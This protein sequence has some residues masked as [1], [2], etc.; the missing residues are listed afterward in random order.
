MVWIGMCA[1]HQSKWNNYEWKTACWSDK[2]TMTATAT[3]G[4]NPSIQE[5]AAPSTAD[6][7][8]ATHS[9]PAPV[10]IFIKFNYVQFLKCVAWLI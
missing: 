1:I 6:Q 4:Q 10:P 9:L 5:T 8:N 2:M 7:W 3:T